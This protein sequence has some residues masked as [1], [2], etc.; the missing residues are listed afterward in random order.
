MEEQFIFGIHAVEEALAAGTLIDKIVARKGLNGEQFARIQQ[1]SRDKHVRIQ[2]TSP[3]VLDRITQGN[4]QGVIAFIN[5]IKY[6]ELDALLKQLEQEQRVPLIVVLDGITDVRNFGAIVRSAN[7][8]GVDAIVVQ[9]KGSAPINGESVKT[10][11]GALLHTPICLTD[12][13]FFAVKMLRERGLSIVAATE[14]GA[15]DY[16]RV[17]LCRPTAIIMGAEDKGISNQ[18]L[19]LCDARARIPMHGQI[20]SLNVSVAA[21]IMLFEAARQRQTDTTIH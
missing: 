13:N 2:Y 16:Y 3:D 6:V 20:E 9:R 7:C 14:K 11:A 21:G 18:L 19:K 15:D 4:H 1:L 17:D 8:A 5:Q 12:K 10:S